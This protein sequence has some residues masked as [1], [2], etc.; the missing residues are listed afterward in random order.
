[1]VGICSFFL[2]CR[3]SSRIFLENFKNSILTIFVPLNII[4]NIW[5]YTTLINFTLFRQMAY[6][7]SWVAN[8]L[9]TMHPVRMKYCIRA[10]RWRC[11]L[12]CIGGTGVLHTTLW[13]ENCCPLTG[14]RGIRI[15]SKTRDLNV[16]E[17]WILPRCACAINTPPSRLHT[18][19]GISWLVD[20]GGPVVIILAS[21]S[22][23]RGFDPGRSRWIFQSVKIMSMI[24][25]WS[26]VKPR[27]PYRR[28]TA[29][30][31]TSS[32]N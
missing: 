27:V 20:P 30:K 7:L 15:H 14:R 25:F 5:F 24:S 29:R 11:R 10:T 9:H 2:K 12:E 6:Q 28:F 21:G 4:E 3:K 8:S 19:A 22:E 16:C 23:V 18:A 26:E 1:M 31:R 13:P 17:I 32:R